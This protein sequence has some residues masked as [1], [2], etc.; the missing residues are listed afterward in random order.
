ME[1]TLKERLKRSIK[2]SQRDVFVRNDFAK[3][4]GTDR[5]LSRALNQLQSEQVVVRAGYGV[6][7]R[8]TLQEISKGIEQVQ[9]RLG[10]RVRRQV[11]IGGVTVQLGAPSAALNEQ[12][13]QDRRKLA[14]ARRVVEKFQ[15]RTVRARSLEN[16]D[17]WEK[18]GVWVSAFDEWR[19]L[20]TQGEDEQLLAA[21][22][23][24]DEKANRLRQSA[25]Y[26]GLLTQSEVES[27]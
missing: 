11:T 3:F 26:A 6:Y 13:I 14:M 25:P 17:R 9:R 8:P 10:P 15:L 4:G 27:I 24:S 5:Q 19:H 1:S 21:M 22:T 20:L 7:V 23:G 2:K 12:E 18:N 16:L